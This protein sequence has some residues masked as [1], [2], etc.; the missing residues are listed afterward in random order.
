MS[1][2][3]SFP[4]SDEVSSEQAITIQ[5]SG[6]AAYSGAGEWMPAGEAPASDAPNAMAVLHA[7]RRHLLVILST[8]LACAAVTG[9][10]L[11]WVLKPQYKAQALLELKPS[12]P[13]ILGLSSADQAERVGNEFEIFR[14]N[15][16]N[17]LKSRFVIMAAL[18]DPKLK[19]RACIL[20]E[21]A[22]HNTIAWLTDALRIDIGK[23][24]GIMQVSSTQPDRDDAAAI[25]N[26]V[27]EAYMTEV[28]NYDR[29]LR[30]ERLSELQQIS[31]EKESEVRTSA[32]S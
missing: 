24:S 10:S 30:R 7:V 14:E 31:A 11:W 27:I 12:V 1:S 2:N 26:A 22:K 13:T 28:V 18:R 16:Q 19:N 6:M 21:D 4:Q 15:Q 3:E 32:N 9:V 23:N 25:V 8:G 5:P 17:L 29:Q 20:R